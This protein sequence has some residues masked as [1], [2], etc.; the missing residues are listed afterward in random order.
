M[1]VIPPGIPGSLNMYQCTDCGK[2]FKTTQHLTQHK[3]R[4][5]TCTLSNKHFSETVT[6]PRKTTSD[7]LQVTDI[8]NFIKT[9]EEIQNL[10]N[11]KKM[12]EEYKNTILILKEENESL[13]EQLK[14]IQQIVHLPKKSTKKKPNELNNLDVL[15]ISPL[16]NYNDDDYT[17]EKSNNN[18]DNTVVETF[19]I[20]DNTTIATII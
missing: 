4:K 10:L 12:I 2:M 9:T 1:K 19:L 5:K 7:N 18:D 13:K 8:V 15:Y 14:S 3:N 11:D 17:N 6:F 20:S 16:T